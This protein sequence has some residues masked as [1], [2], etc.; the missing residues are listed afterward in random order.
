[1]EYCDDGIMGKPKNTAHRRQKEKPK[2]RI[3]HENT[4][5]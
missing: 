2:H 1:M 3:N 5:G 4:K